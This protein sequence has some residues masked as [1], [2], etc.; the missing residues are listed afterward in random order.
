MKLS[1]TILF[2]LF[3][4]LQVHSQKTESL[5]G[6]S[7][8]EIREHLLSQSVSP[9]AK[10]MIIKHNRARKTAYGFLGAAVLLAIISSNTTNPDTD[11]KNSIIISTGA[12]SCGLIAIACGVSASERMKRAKNYY[13]SSKPIHQ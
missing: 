7:A 4:T 6:M 13:L 9:K 11:N 12:A 5:D 1:F 10:E 2:T 3:L 8:P